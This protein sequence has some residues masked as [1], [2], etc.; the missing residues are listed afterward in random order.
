[1]L[2]NLGLA[3]L[4]HEVYWCGK[5]WRKITIEQ[6]IML[7]LSLLYIDF[8]TAL[9]KRRRDGKKAPSQPLTTM[10]RAHVLP[11]IEKYGDDYEVSMCSCF[12]NILDVCFS[13]FCVLMDLFSHDRA[14]LG[15]Q[16][17]I[18]CSIRLPH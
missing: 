16:N 17:E 18:L 12:C 7:I 4:L 3:C 8:K 15:I 14:C 9:G 5:L 6:Y 13:F 11:L 1:M 10:Q 2:L